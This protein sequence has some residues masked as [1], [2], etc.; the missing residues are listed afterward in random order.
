MWHSNSEDF[1][2]KNALQGNYGRFTTEKLFQ[3]SILVLCPC[4]MEFLPQLDFTTLVD[5]PKKNFGSNDRITTYRGTWHY[6]SRTLDYHTGHQKVKLL[7]H[8]LCEL[9]RNYK[10]YK[11]DNGKLSK[12]LTTIFEISALDLVGN[13]KLNFFS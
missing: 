6:H 5:S 8:I 13:W 9:S 7:R 10:L 11:L 3:S 1:C 2:G 12:L 4:Y